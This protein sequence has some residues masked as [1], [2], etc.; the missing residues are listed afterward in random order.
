MERSLLHGQ[1]PVEYFRELVGEAL[2]RRRL[3]ASN[4]TEY[5]LVNLLCQQV[6][7]ASAGADDSGEPLAVRL[8][9][10]LACGGREQQARL[11]RLGDFTLFVAG[12]FPDSLSRKVV[13]VDYYQSIGEYAY[14]SLSQAGIGT[15]ADTYGE[16]AAKFTAFTDV[17]GDVGEQ[18]LPARPVDLLRAYD[19]WVK[20]GSQRRAGQLLDRGLLP[21]APPRRQ[22]LQ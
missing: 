17:L 15:F 19:A 16:L 9:R 7:A 2:A 4:L 18:A 6:A 1:T 3:P 8:G 20:T 10:A 5:Y 21:P 12:F 14:G 11:R 13:D 22:Y